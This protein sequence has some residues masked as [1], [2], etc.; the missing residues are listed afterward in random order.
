MSRAGF[1]SLHLL[2]LSL[3]LNLFLKKEEKEMKKM[4]VGLLSGAL[5]LWMATSIGAWGADQRITYAPYNSD[6]CYNN[7]W[8]IAY[9]TLSVLHMVWSDK[10]DLPYHAGE[11][12]Y[13]RS[14]DNGATWP[15]ETRLTFRTTQDNGAYSPGVA[16]SGSVVHVVWQDSRP[17]LTSYWQIYY[18]RSTNGGVTWSAD[19]NISNTSGSS[20]VAP[21]VVVSGNIVHVVWQDHRNGYWQIWYMRSTDG[22]VTWGTQTSLSDYSLT[23]CT[24]PSIAVSGQYVHVAWEANSSPGNIYYRQ[25]T[26][27]GDPAYW[28]PYQRLDHD[29]YTTCTPSIATSGAYVNV[30]WS[31]TRDNGGGRV[32]Y[33]HSTNNGGSWTT[34]VPIPGSQTSISS[35]L[36]SIAARGAIL[37]VAWQIGN[38]QPG[39]SQI[40]SNLSEDYGFDWD[41]VQLVSDKTNVTSEYPSVCFSTSAMGTWGNA[42]WSDNR[43][44]TVGGTQG[45]EVFR[46][47][48]YYIPANLPIGASQ[49]SEISNRSLKVSPNPFVNFTTVSGQEK[50]D[51]VLYDISGKKVGTYRGERIGADV[52]PGVYFLVLP[53]RNVNPVRIVKVR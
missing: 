11:I 36:P 52:S 10:R 18:K 37:L 19:R 8:G 26:N 28:N 1:L 31:D 7:A 38:S 16:V 53:G 44:D 29:S 22:G 13:N 17:N 39:P 14:T 30:V 9:G 25:N 34:E 32:Y 21:S 42:I 15:N 43:A 24:Y 50:G 27:Y 49:V 48:F 46:D 40:Y 47:G 5:V 2:N 6:V 3:I 35:V 51:F 45:T 4:M 41:G 23:Q 33:V 20:A 12:Y